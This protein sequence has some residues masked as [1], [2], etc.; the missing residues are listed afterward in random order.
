VL[1][2]YCSFLSFAVFR[3][4]LFASQ[5]FLLL[6]DILEFFWLFSLLAVLHGTLDLNFKLSAF[7][8]Q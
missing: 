6:D 3:A 7:C 4:F 5:F 1:D 8:D 2:F